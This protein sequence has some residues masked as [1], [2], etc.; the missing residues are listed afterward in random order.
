M[1]RGSRKL[2]FLLLFVSVLIGV[3]GYLLFQE[4]F[5]ILSLKETQSLEE[6]SSWRVYSN[7][8]YGYS[9][10]Y[11]GEFGLREGRNDINNVVSIEK[12]PF[13]DDYSVFA[14]KFKES[15]FDR[16]VKNEVSFLPNNH[17]IFKEPR[18]IIIN[19]IRGVRY[20][21]GS[22]TS[23]NKLIAFLLPLTDNSYFEFSYWISDAQR[24]QYDEIALKILSTFKLLNN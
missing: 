3:G 9:I 5:P 17:Y 1:I 21:R 13:Q 19:N 4:Y 20:E 10:K 8:K 24:A 2:V 23:E 12:Q 16:F 14:A 6:T 11:P 22:Y 7:T 18:S 15:S